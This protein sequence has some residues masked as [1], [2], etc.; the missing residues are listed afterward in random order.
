MNVMSR[1]S[2]C[3]MCLEALFPAV[4]CLIKGTK[5]WVFRQGGSSVAMSLSPSRHSHIGSECQ[6][7]R[8][9]LFVNF[10]ETVSLDR[11]SV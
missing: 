11:V 8:K 9:A 1:D 3:F 10:R 5:H 6:T 2:C 7:K 4:S